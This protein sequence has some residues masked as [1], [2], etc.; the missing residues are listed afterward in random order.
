MPSPLESLGLQ[1][2]PRE[3]HLPLLHQILGT[4][5]MLTEAVTGQMETCRAA[6]S[7]MDC[8]NDY[9]K[10]LEEEAQ[11]ASEDQTIGYEEG[12]HRWPAFCA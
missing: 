4:E 1:K 2:G 11:A 8:S 7:T 10:D 9:P 5:T 3:D 6:S 12:Q